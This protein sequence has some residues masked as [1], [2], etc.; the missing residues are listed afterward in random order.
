M[1]FS[2]GGGNID[3]ARTPDCVIWDSVASFYGRAGA[4]AA[5]DDYLYFNFQNFIT[6]HMEIWRSF[7]GIVWKPITTNG[8]GYTN[9]WLGYTMKV[10]DGKLYLGTYN[11]DDGPEIWN[12]ESGVTWSRVVSGGFGDGN[13]HFAIGN[14][15]VAGS[16]LYVATWSSNT[17]SNGT[18]IWR[19]RDGLHW[20]QVNEDGFSNPLRY[21]VERC[22]KSKIMRGLLRTKNNIPFASDQEVHTTVGRE[23]KITLQATDDEEEDRLSYRVA[24]P[25]ENG[26]VFIQG[27]VVTYTPHQ[28]FAGLDGFSFVADDG[29]M[30]SNKGHI[31]I[32]VDA[33]KGGNTGL[34][35][36]I[37]TLTQ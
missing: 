36:F 12:T 26:G 29:K 13:V 15:V 18:E 7:D 22:P 27:N 34:G 32:N 37:S 10:F 6:L 28:G 17:M 20:E 5:L 21:K 9:N 33:G 11:N 35:C 31:A 8:F 30:L 23:I 3:I 19:T 16:Q 25:P 24:S 14:M 1:P 4:I 2:L